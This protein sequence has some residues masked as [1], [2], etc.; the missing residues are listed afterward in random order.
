MTEEEIRTLDRTWDN[1][2][3]CFCW[4]ELNKDLI[5]ELISNN[6]KYK[7]NLQ[8]QLMLDIHGYSVHCAVFYQNMYIYLKEG[9]ALQKQLISYMNKVYQ[10]YREQSE[11][12]YAAT[13]QVY[14]FTDCTGRI[15]DQLVI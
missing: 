5:R 2:H 3:A 7:L 13:R 14:K 8:K 9:I 11:R 6:K 1:I 15:L 12:E 4:S 10:M